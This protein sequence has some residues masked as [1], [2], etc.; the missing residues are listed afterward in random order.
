MQR[1]RQFRFNGCACLGQNSVSPD[2][3]RSNCI[4]WLQEVRKAQQDVRIEQMLSNLRAEI[5]E[6]QEDVRRESASD[7]SSGHSPTEL[8]ST[9]TNRYQVHTHSP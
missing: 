3:G 6:V 1:P 4:G 7:V 2:E 5:M 8:S 9:S